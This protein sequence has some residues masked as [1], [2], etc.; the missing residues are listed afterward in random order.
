MGSHFGVGEFT[1]HFR[2]YVRGD[3]D[4]HC[5]YDLDFDP[6]QYGFVSKESELARRLRF[7]F[8]LNKEPLKAVGSLFLPGVWCSGSMFQSIG[9]G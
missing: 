6:W 7:P 9:S 3:W 4:A 5:G 2:T 8:G 1:T